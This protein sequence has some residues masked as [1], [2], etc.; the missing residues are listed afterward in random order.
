MGA[1][2]LPAS[3]M[4]WLRG[5]SSGAPCPSS[6]NQSP[7]VDA[8]ARSMCLPQ[9]FKGCPKGYCILLREY[10]QIVQYN[11]GGRILTGWRALAHRWAAC[12]VALPARHA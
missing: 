8:C 9:P 6:S 4:W 2:Q 11:A 10:Y 3:G 5:V 1:S 12:V 7:D